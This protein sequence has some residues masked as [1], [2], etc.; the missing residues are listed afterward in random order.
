[1]YRSA[2]A[3]S[4][5]WTPHLN[6]QVCVSG[7]ALLAALVGS[8]NRSTCQGRANQFVHVSLVDQVAIDRTTALAL[9]G[10]HTGKCA[11]SSMC[12]EDTNTMLQ[13]FDAR[14]QSVAVIQICHVCMR[15]IHKQMPARGCAHVHCSI[16]TAQRGNRAL[17]FKNCCTDF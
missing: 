6:V 8:I 12:I 9:V 4:S 15:S 3:P 13:G 17:L 10:G 2:E 16:S 1:M 7:L 5:S 11:I 14:I